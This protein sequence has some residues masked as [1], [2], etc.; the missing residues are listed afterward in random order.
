[1]KQ[2]LCILLCLLLL[3]GCGA[4]PSETTEPTQTT[5]PVTVPTSEPTVPPPTVSAQVL[6]LRE[7]LGRQVKVS[8]TAKGGVLQIEFFDPEDLRTLANKLANGE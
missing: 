7:N 8:A 6:A 1:M 3:S 5:V 4:P 2:L